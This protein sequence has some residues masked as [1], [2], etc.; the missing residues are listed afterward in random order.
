MFKSNAILNISFIEKGKKHKI[1]RIKFIVLLFISFLIFFP[2]INND[3]LLDDGYLIKKNIDLKNFNITNEFFKSYY[4]VINREGLYYRPFQMI[5]YALDLKIYRNN[6]KGMHVTGILLHAINSFLVFLFTGIFFRKKTIPFVVGLLF[7]IHP[8]NSSAVIY[9]SSRSDLLLCFFSLLAMILFYKS[10][11]YKNRNYVF[12]YFFFICALLSKEG[13]IFLPFIFLV[14][15]HG[16]KSKHK[17]IENFIF[18]STVLFYILL[19]INSNLNMFNGLIGE[20]GLPPSFVFWNVYNVITKYIIFTIYPFPSYLMHSTD[21]VFFNLY[22]AISFVFFLIFCLSIILIGKY[23]KEKILTISLASFFILLL[24]MFKGINHFDDNKACMAEHWFYLPSIFWFIIVVYIANTILKNKKRLKKTLII[25]MLIYFSFFTFT[26][27][28]NYAN[29]ELFFLHILKYYPESKTARSGIIDHYIKIK[30]FDNA[31]YHVNQMI[32]YDSQSAD[33]YIHCA[34]YY[35]AKGDFDKADKCLKVAEQKKRPNN[36]QRYFIVK[37]LNAVK[38]GNVEE[39]KSI[40]QSLLIKGIRKNI[41]YQNLAAIYFGN[42]EWDNALKVLS[43]GR[44]FIKD[45][46]L[47]YCLIG[48]IFLQKE[49]SEKAIFYYKKALEFPFYGE[50]LSDEQLIE[51]TIPEAKDKMEV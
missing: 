20:I 28:I 24:P 16:R 9:L 17:F 23:R 18:F 50:G 4:P 44:R 40:M 32:M 5:S 19:R 31:K 13:A 35:I 7:C 51:K 2:S 48:E 6:I 49:E 27:S 42:K 30:Y 14:L 37:T 45:K 8:I 47:L 25:V 39:G 41:L 33:G 36:L 34:Q 22:L 29:Q 1:M 10:E 46:R 15:Q 12:S 38:L 21:F 11:S 3:L 26:N 43:E